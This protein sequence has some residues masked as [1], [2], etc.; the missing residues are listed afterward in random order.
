M[1]SLI[2][3]MI[4]QQPFIQA[5]P[6]EPQAP[7]LAD[8]P[9]LPKE[10][11]K[12]TMAIPSKVQYLSETPDKP[13]VVEAGPLDLN[14]CQSHQVTCRTMHKYDV[15]AD[16]RPPSSPIYR[17][18]VHSHRVHITDYRACKFC[19]IKPNQETNMPVIFSSSLLQSKAKYFK[20]IFDFKS[21]PY[22][23]L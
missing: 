12:A 20:H 16:C 10:L 13:Q 23:A 8:T 15:M 9:I 4:S 11:D 2:Q 17:L 3:K 18:V 14:N 6:D 22:L 19:F 21:W 5:T 1:A 7:P